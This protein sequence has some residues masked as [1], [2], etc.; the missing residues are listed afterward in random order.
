MEP[1]TLNTILDSLRAAIAAKP[2][3]VY[4]QTIVVPE[5]TPLY[6]NVI[7]PLLAVAMTLAFTYWME[8]WR[9]KRQDKRDSKQAESQMYRDA[10]NRSKK[11]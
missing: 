7:V 4:L 5:G 6:V 1:D 11:L 9:N 10:L 3:T 8:R 2:D